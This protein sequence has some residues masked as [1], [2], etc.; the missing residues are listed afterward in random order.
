MCSVQCEAAQ[1]SAAKLISFETW[2]P[3][4][5]EEE[6]VEPLKSERLHCSRSG[7]LVSDTIRRPDPIQTWAIELPSA[8][9]ALSLIIL[10]QHQSQER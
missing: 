9:I 1:W 3:Q 4:S 5:E 2:H 6:A 7:R 8:M 10:F